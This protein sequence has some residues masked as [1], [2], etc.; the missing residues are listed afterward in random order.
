MN[1]AQPSP[2]CGWCGLIHGPRCP[3][4]AAIEY[5]ADGI[6]VKRVEF[7]QPTYQPISSPAF[8]GPITSGKMPGYM[9]T[10]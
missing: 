6:T 1:T 5:H 10:S 4:V 3:S 8:P 2:T 9:R 7:V